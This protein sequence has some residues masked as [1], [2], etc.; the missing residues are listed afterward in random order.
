MLF[1]QGR[2]QNSD[3]SFIKKQLLST[4]LIQICQQS[5]W[6]QNSSKTFAHKVC[7][8]KAK[9]RFDFSPKK[10]HL[11]LWPCICYF[12]SCIQSSAM[13]SFMS[14]LQTFF[15]CPLQLRLSCLTWKYVG[16]NQSW[17]YFWKWCIEF[18]NSVLWRIQFS[19]QILQNLYMQTFRMFCYWFLLY[20]QN[21]QPTVVSNS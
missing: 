4:F 3:S 15:F 16:S 18:N 19:A 12:N 2:K 1:T 20:I 17:T 9:S 5:R 8:V 13:L 11:P 6:Q 14:I 10:K 7:S 21:I